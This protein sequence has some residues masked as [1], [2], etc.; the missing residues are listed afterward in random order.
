MGCVGF[1]PACPRELFADLSAFKKNL[2]SYR[3]MAENIDINYPEN[4]ERE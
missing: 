2:Y 4:V 3:T 1:T